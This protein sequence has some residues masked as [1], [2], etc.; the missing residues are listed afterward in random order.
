[1]ARWEIE[2]V[3]TRIIHYYENLSQSD[4]KKMVEHFIAQEIPKSTIYD[5]TTR[6][7]LTGEKITNRFR[8]PHPLNPPTEV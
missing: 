8:V 3:A 7:G 1:M 6:Y 4:K 5:T 2:H